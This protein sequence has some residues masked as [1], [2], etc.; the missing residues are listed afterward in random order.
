LKKKKHSVTVRRRYAK[1]KVVSIFRALAEAAFGFRKL[2]A[3]ASRVKLKEDP[4]QG[5]LYSIL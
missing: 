3:Q 4:E 5:E 1:K 2:A